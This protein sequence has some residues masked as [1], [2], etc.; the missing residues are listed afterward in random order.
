MPSLKM[1]CGKRK[2]K[3]TVDQQGGVMRRA[4]CGLRP[5]CL[6]EFCYAMDGEV[7]ETR[8]HC[9]EVFADRDFTR[10]AKRCGGVAD[11]PA[12]LRGARVYDLAAELAA[13][14]R[15]VSRSSSS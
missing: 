8:Q 1:F 15:S 11:M 10:P 7:G 14:Q 4:D 12:M 6:C 3:H 2:S 13:C 5:K 9:G